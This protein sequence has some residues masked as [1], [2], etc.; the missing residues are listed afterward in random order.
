MNAGIECASG[1]R[2][3]RQVDGPVPRSWL[4]RAAPESTAPLADKEMPPRWNPG[5]QLKRG[6]RDSALDR[7]A[8][9]LI[10]SLARHDRQPHFLAQG[11]GHESTDGVG[12]PAGSFHDLLD[13]R[14][15]GPPQ[16][17]QNFGGLA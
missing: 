3:A 8:A 7:V 9:L 15:A 11:A 5:G 1:L 14:A 13:G 17:V 4:L 2:R 16:K 6:S 10:R 12:L